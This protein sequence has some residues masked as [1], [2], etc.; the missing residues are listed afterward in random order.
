MSRA[1]WIGAALLILIIA[2]AAGA[3]EQPALEI[4]RVDTAGFPTVSVVVVGP[5]EAAGIDLAPSAFR[6]LEDGSE[7]AFE[8]A[9]LTMSGLEVVLLLDVSGSMAGA[10]LEAA[11]EAAVSFLDRMPP[12]ARV[13]VVAF[14]TSVEVVAGFDATSEELRES[15]LELGLAGNTALYDAVVVGAGQLQAARG[16]ER[17]LVLLSDGGDTISAATLEEAVAGLREAGTT[18]YAVEL[19]T[20]ESDPEALTA[21]ADATG[22]RVVRAE[23][24]AALTAVYGELASLIVNRYELT[25]TSQGQ[26]ATEL[27]VELTYGETSV[28]AHRTIRLPVAP[29]P[30]TG[31]PELE[32]PPVVPEETVV[33]APEG[34]VDRWGLVAG[35]TAVYLALALVLS[36]LFLPARRPVLLALGGMR[37]R[38][39][40]H[41]PVSELADRAVFLAE[42]ALQRGGRLS[43]LNIALERAGIL[44]RPGEFLVLAGSASLASL[45]VGMIFSGPMV[46]AALVAIT[47]LGFRISL[48]IKRDRRQ[49]AFVDQLG[50]TLQLLAGTLRSGYGVLQAIDIISREAE[51]PTSGE[52]R[53]VVLENR[54]GRDL[55]E[56]LRGVVERVESMDFEWVVE[57]IEI[58]QEVGGDLAEVL[59]AVAATI[60]DRNQIRRQVRALSAEGRLSAVILVLLPIGMALF[61]S[62]TNPTYIAELTGSFAG[63]L[64]IGAG[65]FLMIVG[66]LWMRRV[67]DVEF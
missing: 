52:L 57:A 22:G 60:R 4:E 48:S 9:H 51:A 17:V 24:P 28:S 54:L 19:L 39:Q 43:R 53:R 62:V 27:V 49:A 44:L 41:T 5:P 13:A 45:A 29:P 33:V 21:L 42:R 40:R 8:L 25:Y 26:G 47:L 58:H 14:G 11:K 15:I 30:P 67:V 10:P 37:D 23:E 65:V 16:G 36:A 63:R 59:D 56:A 50:D 66:G 2:P 55:V 20:A 35:I 64:M 34:W 18:L 1:T 3:Q 61:I 46:G 6:L 7:R 12:A 38:V 31:T 32:A